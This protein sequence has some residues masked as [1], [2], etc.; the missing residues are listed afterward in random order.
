MYK[1]GFT[2]CLHFEGCLNLT[3]FNVVRFGKSWRRK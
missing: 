2:A 3:L 1:E